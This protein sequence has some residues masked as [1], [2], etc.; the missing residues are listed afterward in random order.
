[1]AVI[2]FV[3]VIVDFVV[4]RYEI[5]HS[6]CSEFDM[7][8]REKDKYLSFSND[9]V[10]ADADAEGASVNL[11][12]PSFAPRHRL[13]KLISAL[14]LASVATAEALASL[15]SATTSPS[16]PSGWIVIVYVIVYVTDFKKK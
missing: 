14:G 4:Q 16:Y 2:V 7:L 8:R 5:T 11:Q 10:D 12:F 3:I 15:R 6:S 1:M 13:S 9:N